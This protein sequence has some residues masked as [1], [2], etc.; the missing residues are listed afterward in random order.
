MIIRRA[1]KFKLEPNDEQSARLRVLCGHS[2]FV[3]N[4]ALA[5]CNRM[6][7]AGEGIPS[8]YRYG[9]T[10]SWIGH[11]K[12]QEDTSFLKEGYTDCYQQKLKDLAT[13]WSRY[14]DKSL[15]AE[16]PRFKRKGKKS[17]SI[18]FVNFNKYCAIEGRRVKL[19]AKLGFVKFRKSKNITGEIRS[20][21][22]SCAGDNWWISFQTK[23]EVA[24]PVHTSKTAIGID[25]GIAKFVAQSDGVIFKAI[26]PFR[27]YQDRLAK[28]QR[29][30]SKKK[31]FSCN[32]RKQ[33]A[34]IRKIHSKIASIR[35]DYLHK[36]S[37]E[38]SKNHAM[39][40]IEDL[41]IKNMSKSAK[42][43]V[44][45]PGKN[46]KAK[47]GLNKS[48]LDQGWYE[49]RRQLEYKQ[50]WRGGIVVAVNPAYTSQAY[51]KCPT[52]SAD[53]RLTQA[54]F[55]CINCGYENN[56]DV[57]GAIN[58]LERGHRF[59]ACGEQLDH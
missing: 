4:N 30:L 48:I 45:K 19:P 6:L 44:E 43:T 57:V 40:A 56:A 38:I 58:I 32:W 50:L 46:V 18:R 3:W 37:A 5:E 28:E 14:F 54:D 15:Q 49:F 21:T 25:V 52:V 31:K 24:D 36:T 8:Y 9:G 35:R 10:A 39:I 12:E 53:N 11:W 59:L 42:G 17:D 20:C 47:S 23:E 2:R 16:R 33:K 55:K 1:F 34:K 41:R 29:K 7:K 26:S 22:L 13:A 27:K 51:P